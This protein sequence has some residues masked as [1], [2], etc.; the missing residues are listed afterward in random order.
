MEKQTK[1]FI[2]VDSVP[3]TNIARQRRQPWLE[4]ILA[5]LIVFGAWLYGFLNTRSPIEPLITNVLPGTQRVEA[6]GEIFTAYNKDNQL[7]GYA[8]AADATGYGGPIFLLVGVDLQGEIAGV[9]VI[10]QRE[11]P[12]FYSLLSDR[13]FI[14]GFLGQNADQP[15]VLGQDVDSISGA[16]LSAGAVAQ[17]IH[18]AAQKIKTGALESTAPAIRFGLPEIALLA[19]FAGSLTIPRLKN[20]RSRNIL[21][22]GLLLTSIV[23]IGFMLNQPLT[24][25]NFASFLA[26]Y[27]PTWQDH[28][29]WFLMLV[30]VVGL[31][32]LQ[33]R[34]IYCYSIC[35]FGAVQECFGQLSAATPYLPR[36]I[37]RQLRWVP[38]WLAVLALA[39][40][41]AFRQPGA[42]SFEPFGT[43]FS[44][45]AGFFPWMLLVFVLFASLIILRPFC[46]YLCPV[47][48]ILDFI[49]FIRNQVKKIWKTKQNAPAE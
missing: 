17:A 9:Q 6:D 10:E 40:G 16:T 3:R 21:Y 34:N 11:T 49:L 8:A 15:F 48:A 4:S 45:S 35:P 1:R 33:G 30:G 29:Y 14:Q 47:G 5:V 36:G 2:G 26:G 27:W 31:A 41:L 39:L 25:A 13:Q 24:L 19:M 46:Y 38:R 12:G 22:W 18:N 43:L 37:Y 23:I 32:I 28:L 42:A 7:L 20:R 44:F